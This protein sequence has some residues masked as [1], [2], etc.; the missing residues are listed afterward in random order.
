M[1]VSVRGARLRAVAVPRGGRMGTSAHVPSG[2]WRC[3]M[4]G[5]RAYRRERLQIDDPTPHVAVTGRLSSLPARILITRAGALAERQ[6]LGE[7][8]ARRVRAHASSCPQPGSSASRPPKKR[9]K[10][11]PSHSSGKSLVYWIETTPCGSSF[12]V[13]R[14]GLGFGLGQGAAW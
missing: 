1:A 7:D 2:L 12:Q 6:V 8:L 13:A 5:T 3:V 11:Y 14:V 10:V 4:S 9:S